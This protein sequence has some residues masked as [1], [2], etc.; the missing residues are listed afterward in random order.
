[1]VADRSAEVGS[2]LQGPPILGCIVYSACRWSDLAATDPQLCT[3]F[4]S[5]VLTD[6]PP[7]SDFPCHV[8]SSSSWGCEF[9]SATASRYA[10]SH[11]RRCLRVVAS[12]RLVIAGTSR[13]QRQ[14][15]SQASPMRTAAALRTGIAGTTLQSVHWWSRC[16]LNIFSGLT[17][18]AGS[19]EHGWTVC[20]CA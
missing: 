9:Q 2:T 18:P 11:W 3:H 1:M 4:N 16:G 10:G 20:F 8:Q 19:G 13:Q 5:A 14:V 6:L 15:Y 12:L 17:W 7:T